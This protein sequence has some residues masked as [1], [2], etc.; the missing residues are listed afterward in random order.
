MRLVVLVPVLALA[1]IGHTLVG[2]G[3]DHTWSWE[4]PVIVG[5][6]LSA[7]VAVFTST[8]CMTYAIDCYKPLAGQI[9]V[10]ATICKNTFGSGMSYFYNDWIVRSNF[11]TPM[12]MPL[13]T[14]VR[15]MLIGILVGES[16]MGKSLRRLTAGSSIHTL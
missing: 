13:G 2:E 6:P 1:V 11:M 7:F 4:V 14:T 10:T 9:M 5:F 8:I 12:A 3:F 16:G 15:L